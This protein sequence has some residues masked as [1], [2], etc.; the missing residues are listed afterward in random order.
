MNPE[1]EK[2][3]SAIYWIRQQGTTLEEIGNQFGMTRERVRQICEKEKEKQRK[4]IRKD[5]EKI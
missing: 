4:Q 2:R 3:N 5:L 1:K